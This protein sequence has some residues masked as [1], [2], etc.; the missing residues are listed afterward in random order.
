MP[1]PLVGTM[2]ADIPDGVYHVTAD[3]SVDYSADADGQVHGF[4]ILELRNL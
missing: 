4:D 2:E 1:D 3:G